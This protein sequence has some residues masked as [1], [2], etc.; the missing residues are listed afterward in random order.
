[1]PVIINELEI[2]TEAPPESAA[3]AAEGEAAQGAAQPAGAPAL[4]PADVESIVCFQAERAS[5]LYA[6]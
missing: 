5:R 4:S 3:A 6:G 2:V 1:M